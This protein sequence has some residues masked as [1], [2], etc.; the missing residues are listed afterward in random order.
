MTFFLK[1][2]LSRGNERS[3]KYKKN[4]MY[5]F[6]LKGISMCVSFVYVPLLLNTL[7]SEKYAIWL[8]LTSIVSW[9]AMLDIGLGNGL[10][11]KLAAAVANEDLLLAK[12]YVSS[13]YIALSIYMS[14]F[15]LIFVIIATLFI[16]WN[17][18]LNAP[19]MAESELEIL[20]IIVF[21]SFGAHFV[22]NILNS[23]L[24]ALQA[25]ALSSL[26]ATLGQIFSLLVVFMCVKVFNVNSL[27]IL[28]SIV[29][30]T[31]VVIL[32]ISTVFFFTGKYKILKP[33]VKYYDKHLIRSI[34]GLGLNFF[35]IQMMTIFLYQSNN[36]IITHIIGSEGVVEYNIANKYV[37]VIH[38][39][40]VIIVTPLWSATTQAYV[41]GDL[42]WI[43]NTN[44][45][46]NKIAVIFSI[47]GLAMVFV[48]P[49]IYDFWLNNDEVNIALSSTFI[50]LVSEIFRMFY[51][52]Y[53]YIINGIG[54]LRAQL[55]I[56]IIMGILYIPMTILA[57]NWFG[58]TGVLMMGLFVNLINCIWSKY[59][60]TLLIENK[61]SNFWNK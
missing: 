18:V 37:Q 53:G 21:I 47:L 10:R 20:V 40:Y 14:L 57:G 7:D 30:L 61:A 3:V 13:T 50:L 46:L 1:R 59:Q 41:K 44:K 5:M 33:S 32:I 16:P 36:I 17:S 48:S 52:N 49:F 54:K 39:L 29:S 43:K 23:I 8:T 35:V 26:V 31:P 19:N 56:S 42:S 51:G 24:Y 4:A 11:N 34:I 12:R 45:N 22:L 38:V 25:P 15:L 9:V 58:I 60:F 28:G 2:L 55:I 6:A 27:L